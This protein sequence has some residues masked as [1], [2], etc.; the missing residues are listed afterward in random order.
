MKKILLSLGLFLLLILTSNQAEATHLM[1]VD[2]TYTCVNNCTIRVHNRVYR[3]CDGASGVGIM[4]FNFNGGPGCV[5]PTQVAGWIP[6][7][8]NGSTNCWFVSEVTPVCPGT[9]TQCS[10]PSSSIRGVEEYYRYGDFDICNTNCNIYNIEW[11]GQNRN[12]GITSGAASQGIGTTTV[13]V[14]TALTTC[15]NSPQFN[16]PPVPYVCAGQPFTF[17]QGAVDPDGD[18][19]SYSLGACYTDANNTSISYNPGYSATAPLGPSWTVNVN[20]VS[21]DVSFIPNP[22]NV[23]VGVMCVYVQE[24]RNGQLINTIVRD[25]QINVIPC[26]SNS[27]P[28]VPTVA[29]IINGQGQ[30]GSNTGIV[31]GTCINNNLCFD[32]PAIDPNAQDTVTMWWNNGIPG[33]TFF[34]SGVPTNTDTVTGVN[35]RATFCWTP[36]SA[37]VFSFLVEMK[38]D[39]CPNFGFSQFTVTIIVS[40]PLVVAS[41]QPPACDTFTICAVPFQGIPPFTFNWTGQGGLASTD[42]CVTHIYP[43][44]GTYGYSLT[45]TDSLG[46]TNTYT[47]SVV[48]PPIPVA[49]AG[50]DLLYC[51][52]GTDTIGGPTFPDESYVWTPGMFLSDS[53]ISNPVLTVNNPGPTVMYLQYIVT[54]T[55]TISNCVD[56]DTMNVTVS[57]PP[58][59]TFAPVDVICYGNSTGEIDMT[60]TNGLPNFTIAWTGPN[61]FS[62]TNEDI[63]NLF[64]GMYYI[65]ITD[66]AGCSTTDSVEI[67]QPPAPLWTN[68]IG[69]D[70][71]CN[72]GA[73]GSI[74]LT[75]TGDSPPY[76]F[77]WTGPGAFSATTEDISGLVAGTYFITVVDSF[78]CAI[79]DSVEIGEPTPVNFAFNVY[80]AACNGDASG[81]IASH[82][83]GG[84]GNYGYMWSPIGATVDSISNLLA[85]TYVLQV[86]DTCFG[87]D[88]VSLYWEDFEGNAPWTLNVI[89]GVNGA[90]RNFWTI[91]DNAG[92]VLPPGCGAN[93]NG[94]RTLHITS[95]SNPTGG[96][97]YN[98]G[99]NCGAGPCPQ[100]NLRAESPLIN[101]TGYA[102]L[103]LTFDYTSLGDNLLD[104]ASLLY[105]D[106]SGWQVLAASIKSAVCNP[107]QGQWAAF[108]ATLPASCNNIPDLQI[109]FNWTNNEDGLGADPSVA[110]NNIRIMGPAIPSQTICTWTDSATV[111][112]PPVLEDSIVA[113]HNLCF[114]DSAGTLTVFPSGGNGNYGYTWSTGGTTPMINNLPAGV[115]TVTVTDTAYTPAGGI[116]GYLICEIIDTMAITQPP[117][118]ALVASTTPTSCFLGSDGTATVA[119]SGGTPGYTFLWNSNPPQTT[120]T[121][122]GLPTGAYTVYVTDI[123]GCVDSATT[124]VTQPGPIIYTTSSTNATC[125]QPNGTATVNPLGGVGGFTYQWSTTPV[126]TT[127]TAT[128]LLPGPYSVTITDANGCQSFAQV[129][130]GNEPNPVVS[131]DAQTNLLCFGDTDGTATAVA[132]GGT[133]PYTFLW[134]NGQTTPMATNLAAGVHSVIVTDNFGCRDTTTVTITSPTQVTGTTLV[135]HMGCNSTIPDGTVGVLPSGGTPSYTF[136]WNTTPAQTTQ[137]ATGLAPGV[138]TVTVTDANGCDFVIS[139]TVI[140]IPRPDVTAGPAVS[141]CE[142]D[143]GAQ[144]TSFATGGQA[145]YYYVWYCDSSYTYCGLDS[146]N[147][148]D[149]I[150]NPDSSTWYYVYVVDFNGC[151]SDTDS[152]FVT[153]LPKPIVDAGPDI[154]MCGDS[155]PCVIL[156]PTILG[157]A[158]GPFTY[159]W[160][161]G[162]GLNDSTIASPCARPDTTTIYTLIVTAGNG[163]TSE[164]LTVDTLSSV[165][166]HVNPVP[167]A[168]A[169]PDFDICLG[170]TTVL[171]GYG[172]GAGPAYEYQWTP[173]LGLSDTTIANPLANPTVTTWYSLVVYSNDCPSYADSVEVRVHTIPTVEAGWDREICLGETT[174]LDAQASGDST[175]TYTFLWM[176]TV[177]VIGS[178]ALEDIYVSP[179]STTAYWVVATTNWGCESDPDTAV[180][181]VKPTP[182]AEAGPNKTIC[183]GDSVQLEGSYYYTTTDSADPS[184]IYYRWWPNVTIDDT[185]VANPTVWPD[186]SGWYY[187]TID[188]NTCSWTDS[189]FITVIP[190][191]VAT[192]DADTTVICG[193]DSVQLY[194]SGGLGG[195]SFTWSPAAG[196]SDPNIAN[197]LASPDTTTTYTVVV[198]EGGCFDSDS[199]T[200]QVIPT[201]TPAYVSSLPDGCVPHV[202]N[203]IQTSTDGIHYIWDFGDGTPVSN[204]EF[205]THLYESPGIYDVTLTVVNEGA[206]AASIVE[207]QV[208][209][210]DT[211]KVDF[212]SDPLPPIEMYLPATGVEFTNLTTGA[213]VYNWNFGDGTV[214]TEF[215]PNHVYTEPGQYFVT[216]IATNDNGCH[217]RAIHGPFIVM[218]PELFIPNVFSP[219]DDGINDLFLP[220]YTGH[221]PF[222]LQ[223]YDRWGVLIFETRNK[224][225][226]W[227]GKDMKGMDVVEGVYYYHVDI[228]DKQY[229]GSVT[230]V[231]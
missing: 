101:T 165:T 18:S 97:V 53:L 3:D 93:N 88:S 11:T 133:G 94:D 194:S 177:G 161:P 172:H 57:Y 26:P 144:L 60:I 230:M 58:Q 89:S 28:A 150:A 38:D 171:Q 224:T 229:T 65:T 87:A 206:C 111:G 169:G 225:Q 189:V 191:M 106:G 54:A 75:V 84:H 217:G 50:P 132:S 78:G 181:Y 2:L 117:A 167:I 199:I 34:E 124:A 146:T 33:G 95:L 23:E 138:Y 178:N 197:P 12:G 51:M 40:D 180:V 74:E 21:G 90:D 134:S 59:L 102:G 1:G 41:P 186:G 9:V 163:C 142:G 4:S 139:D 46:C 211:A 121:A 183:G 231:R 158:P 198:E 184:Q 66:S 32:L 107:G 129:A 77:F 203:F 85:G 166:V 91:S 173:S 140:Q 154:W 200:I 190:E 153:E 8:N 193:V 81:I 82:I 192:I 128:A 13:T 72:G 71:C 159:N 116:L 143:G 202:V 170:D 49:D 210:L 115:Y 14:N 196:L 207:V 226:G 43:G 145:P 76:N 222:N 123:N 157:N 83:T 152:V 164:L 62:S 64:A 39:A 98:R 168:E 22:G 209:V 30:G 119:V 131:I 114:G 96:A 56:M 212:T 61:G 151:V 176:D 113:V 127:Q 27:L 227:N 179:D 68:L 137:Q 63:F 156:N 67:N 73:D 103:T 223:I 15:N 79:D 37:G 204:E 100:T 104:N 136:V 155:A 99:G 228:G 182:I 175:A 86:S 215:S 7:N 109:G 149:P 112:E 6:C 108:S 122:T 135:Q 31:V 80:D 187:L 214:S 42:S 148:D 29:N 219:N 160:S 221:Q 130:V 20:P 69:Q 120:Q 10:N 125:G 52:S 110:V 195:A 162:V 126:Q 19:L 188:Y 92:G 208:N 216:L 220:Q 185:T 213:S 35:P 201:P 45:M 105:N 5:A 47:D 141:F 55:N 218:T 205:P 147:D 48:I 25:M 36:T 17:N 16:N 24:W 70:V 174:I 118:L 44:P